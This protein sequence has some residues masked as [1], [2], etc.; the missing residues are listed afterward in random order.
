MHNII[1][2]NPTPTFWQPRDETLT[3]EQSKGKAL[4]KL[5]I[6]EPNVLVTV[7]SH[8]MALSATPSPV[9][10]DS[11]FLYELCNLLIFTSVRALYDG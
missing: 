10:I 7:K 6:L 1:G 5:S 8:L 9:N 3:K 2:S 4:T 11:L